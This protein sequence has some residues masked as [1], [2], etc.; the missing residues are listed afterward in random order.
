MASRRG[1]TVP[2]RR[3]ASSDLSTPP[4]EDEAPPIINDSSP[5]GKKRKAP[6]STADAGV[7][8]RKQDTPRSAGIGKEQSEE[9]TATPTKRK[10][11]REA[12]DQAEETDV[13]GVPEG[14]T[15][16]VEAAVTTVVK[17]KGRGKAAATV[18]KE[19]LKDGH[20]VKGHIDAQDSPVKTPNKR[21]QRVKEEVE[22]KVKEEEG[23][24]EDPTK[25]TPTKRKRKPKSE[26]ANDSKPDIKSAND[27]N[28][29][30]DPSDPST[31][32]AKPKRK[33]KT[34]EEKA[35]EAM[36]LAIRTASH[37]LHLGAHVSAGGGVHNSITNA[38]FIGANAFALF[39]KSQRKWENPALKPEHSLSFKNMC[40]EHKYEANKFVVPHGSYLVNLAAKDSEKSK[41]AYD[42]FVDDLKRCEELGIKLYN[43][44]PGNTNGEPRD[45][46]LGRI[47]ACL[48]R[49]HQETNGVVTL[50]ENMAAA[51]NTIGGTFQDLAGIIERVADKTRVGVCLDTCHAFAAGYDLRT[52][53]AFA[54]T[55]KEFDDVIG[56]KYLRA[57]HL[58]DS[59]APFNSRRDLHFNI[60]F[61]FL[62][63]R[64]FWNVVNEKR[65]WGIPLVLETP[66]DE[67][68]KDEKG[69]AVEDK[70]VW[71]REIKMLEG[72]VGM[73]VDGKEFRKLEVEL[74]AKGVKERERLQE[75]VDRKGAEKVKK[76]AKGGKKKR[77]GKGK[78]EDEDGASSGLSDAESV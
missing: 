30:N 65:F 69:K 42:S 54:A 18:V 45:E 33:R 32:P 7:K 34:A 31:A 14:K 11:A 56:S 60:G 70:G 66:I 27:T 75:V 2:S 64:A 10:G 52:P 53:E 47:A 37:C 61:G 50:L 25:S 5:Q 59:K 36:P 3:A 51:N 72:L 29:E 24:A 71:A 4:T 46:A 39:L 1:D 67:E 28:P 22:V 58:N 49:A 17:K 13:H 23:A 26:V 16:I 20:S 76:A 38:L 40:T 15:E 78:G 74:A 68:K 57:V 9:P 73:Y 21:R 19:E 48:N 43:F 77:G 8:R 63:L 6:G 12:E 35:A 41:Q 62:G 55:M 44:H